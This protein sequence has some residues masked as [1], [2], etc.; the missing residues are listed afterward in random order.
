MSDQLKNILMQWFKLDTDQQQPEK[1]IEILVEALASAGF[2]QS[3]IRQEI[4]KIHQWL[5]DFDKDNTSAL[6][7]DK[8]Y[9]SKRILSNHEKS[10]LDQEAQAFLQ[11][12]LQQSLISEQIFEKIMNQLFLLNL[13]EINIEIAQLVTMMVLTKVI[14]KEDDVYLLSTLLNMDLTSKEKIVH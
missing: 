6:S 4:R 13:E 8:A 11:L 7:N 2:D 3:E 14:D 10:F 1:E 5:A 12:T 9:G